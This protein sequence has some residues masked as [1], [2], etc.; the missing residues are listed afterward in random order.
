MIQKKYKK[1]KRTIEAGQGLNKPQA[2]TTIPYP[3]GETPGRGDCKLSE[4][5][6]VDKE[7]YNAFIVCDPTLPAFA[8]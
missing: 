3:T 4:L 8:H 1:A 7:V 2:K 6:N 5:L